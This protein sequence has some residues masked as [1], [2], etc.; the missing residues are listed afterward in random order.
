MSGNASPARAATPV[1][2]RP[3]GA[4]L[5]ATMS[6]SRSSDS[7]SAAVRMIA[8][9]GAPDASCSRIAPT[10]PNCPSMAAPAAAR[11][12]GAS[13]ATRPLAAPALRRVS[14]IMRGG[15]RPA[16]RS[17]ERMHAVS[18]GA[19]SSTRALIVGTGR[20]ALGP[21]HTVSAS[22]NGWHGRQS[23]RRV[24]QIRKP[25]PGVSRGK[26]RRVA[27]RG[28]FLRVAAERAMR[29]VAEPRRAAGPA[30]FSPRAWP[31]RR[32]NAHV[33]TV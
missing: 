30:S 26:Q 31:F 14:G 15:S 11:N 10:A 20:R 19:R 13:A 33:D 32:C 22:A 7:S 3:I 29:F 9:H 17:A 12:S 25:R 18:H 4:M 5:P 27:P 1:S 16:S 2:T 28:P 23:R 6:P 21:V 8:S 24:C